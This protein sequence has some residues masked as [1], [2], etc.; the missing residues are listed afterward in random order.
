MSRNSSV[1]FS[2]AVIV[3]SSQML[4]LTFSP[5]TTQS[6]SLMGTSVN[7]VTILSLLFPLTYIILAIPMSRWLDRNFKQAIFFGTLFTGLGGLLR[8]VLPYSFMFQLGIQTLISI[9]QPLIL[10]SLSIVAV[11]YFE[12]KDR[13]MAISVGSLAMFIGVIAA[14]AGGL[15]IFNT[16]GY[17]YMLLIEAVPGIVALVTLPVFLKNAQVVSV[18]EVHHEKFSYSGLHFKL[19]AM[20]FVGMGIFDALDTWLE[21]ML[22]NY[23]LA[24]SAGD[25]IA[26]MT[27]M[28]IVGAAVLPKPVVERH[29]RRLAVSVII[30]A[31]FLSLGVL[32]FVGNLS[33]ITATI[34]IEGFFLL[35]GLPIILE[36]GEKATPVRYQGRVTSLLMLFG[37]LGGIVMIA[38]GEFTFGMG[39]PI[40]ALSLIAF[41]IVLIP[42]LLITP[43]NVSV[44]IPETVTTGE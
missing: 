36:W 37:N 2:Y 42:V 44:R 15:F 4:W 41:V 21:P 22:S 26:L 8:I 9:G 20:L 33:L 34:A 30:G 18:P 16:I 7:N 10:G 11:Y 17:Y 40:T 5:V 38:M 6:A 14:T 27:F 39:N 19:A 31:S 1:L 35:A 28:G 3:A 12:E 24:G 32:G 29:K 25:L 43:T 13:P 23:G